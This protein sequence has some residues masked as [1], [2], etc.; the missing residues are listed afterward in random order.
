MKKLQMDAVQYVKE[1]LEFYR[2]QMLIRAKKHKKD[3][4]AFNRQATSKVSFVNGMDRTLLLLKKRTMK[5]KTVL[6]SKEQQEEELRNQQ[7]K[8]LSYWNEYRAAKL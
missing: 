4:V 5:F 7:A 6:S 1:L 2:Q 8:K 3:I